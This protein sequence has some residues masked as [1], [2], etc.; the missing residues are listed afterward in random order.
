MDQSGGQRE[1]GE[2]FHVTFRYG[3]DDEDAGREHGD[4][5]VEG[6]QSRVPLKSHEPSEERSKCPEPRSDY[7]QSDEAQLTG[8]PDEI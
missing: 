3:S 2:S 1:P 6:R 4:E 7:Q 5:I 8:E